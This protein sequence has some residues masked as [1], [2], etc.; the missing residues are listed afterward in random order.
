M[1]F[2]HI[3]ALKGGD[4][5]ATYA[6][7]L[8]R[9][10]FFIRIVDNVLAVGLH[11]V[12]LFFRADDDAFPLAKTRSGRYEVSADNVFFHSFEAVYLSTDG[13]FVQHLGGFLEL[14]GTH[15]TLRLQSRTGDALQYLR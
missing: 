4:G 10:R 8:L 11:A 15:E 1:A 7:L 14:C 12:V 13:S 9:C 5:A 6:R 3:L 2:N